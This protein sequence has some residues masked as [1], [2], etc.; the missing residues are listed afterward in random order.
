MSDIDQMTGLSSGVGAPPAGRPALDGLIRAFRA[1]RL[2]V[3]C[4]ALW[5]AGAVA[6][7]GHLSLN[8]DEL[9]A[10][11]FAE[12]GPAYLFGTGWH[13]ET[14]PPLYYLLLDGWMAVFGDSA[15]AARA[16]SLLAAVL[17]LPVLW[18]IARRVGLD[19][20]AWLAPA[21]FAT[22]A[23]AM[24]YALLARSYALWTL[25]VAVAILALVEALAAPPRRVSR[26]GLVFAGAALAALY[27]HDTTVL[28]LAAANLVYLAVWALRRP[29]VPQA[30]FSWV[31]PQALV[32][33][34]GIPQ[35]LII[36]EQRQSANINW[37]G[38]VSPEWV[39]KTGSEIL[40]GEEYPFSVLRGVALA[41]SLLLLLV[42]VPM[43]APRTARPLA[44]LALAG[45]AL[46]C[47]A[48]LVVSRV[49]IWLLLPVT[50]LQ[51]AALA[52]FRQAWAIAAVLAVGAI[53]TADCL[54]SLDI[55]P[56]RDCLAEFDAA[57]SPDD[58]VVLF[59]ATPAMAFRYYGAG[60]G[61]EF[62][63]W[64]VNSFDQIGTALRTIDDETM[65]LP[66]TSLPRLRASLLQGRAVWLVARLKTHQNAM[67]TLPKSWS[68]TPLPG[69][70]G[71]DFRRIAPL[72]H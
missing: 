64:D 32:L 42:L 48:M 71:I 37:L 59:N 1:R 66:L 13:L 30:L 6:L 62:Y 68:V 21:L 34:A 38:N 39:L 36:L 46:L 29:L 25:F 31:W 15:I 45:A 24:R 27:C 23:F 33:S 10:L 44:G 7:L 4:F 17:T 43:R 56:W 55:E 52:R 20:M 63:R 12:Q 51:A 65:Y 47:I 28:F 60:V 11:Y 54:W 16:P 18:R 41:V 26:W 9:F 61:G 72:L 2:L 53:N 70:C 19:R 8:Q 40:S 67:N 35:G 50:V 14:N 69:K 22:S 3:L 58:V 57:R 5:I 49:G